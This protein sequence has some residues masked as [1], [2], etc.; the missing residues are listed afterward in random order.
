MKKVLRGQASSKQVKDPVC[1]FA[2]HILSE[3]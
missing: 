2:G 3:P 1:M